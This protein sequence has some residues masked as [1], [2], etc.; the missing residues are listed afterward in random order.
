MSRSQRRNVPATTFTFF[1]TRRFLILT[2]VSVVALSGLAISQSAALREKLRLSAA[3]KPAPGPQLPLPAAARNR[4]DLLRVMGVKRAPGQPFSF[5]PPAAPTVSATKTD[6]LFNDVDNDLQADPGDT[7]KYT[8]NINASGSDATGV[9]FT[10]TVDPNT[11]FVPGSLRATPVAVDDTYAATG[12]I[13]ISVAAPGVLGNDFAGI[14]SASI[15]APP[16]TSANGGDVTLNADGSFTYNPPA[17]FEGTDTF[18]YTLTNSEGSNSATVTINVSG[19][20]WFI[21]N[22]ASCPCDGRLTTPFNTLASFAAVNNG[23]GNNPAANDN[24]FLYESASDYVG[25]VTLL[26]GQRFIGQDATASL[27][28]ITGLTPPAGSDPLPVTNS[29]NGTIVNITTGSAITVASGNTLTGFTGGDST[30]DIT[31]TGFGTL[32]ISD[33]TLNGT[34]QALNLTT[35]TLAATFGSISSTNSATTGI[36]LTGVAGTLT[37]PTTTITN[38]TGIGMSVGTSSATLGFGNTTSTGS[39]GT[40]V[41]LLT[42]SG[43][44]TFGALNISPD[45]NQR[46]LLA[47][48]N[49]N[50]ITSASGTISTSGATAIEVTRGVG[51]T[52]LAISQTSVSASGGTNGIVLSN[53]NG[54]FTVTGSGGACSTSVNCTGGAVLN[55]TNAVLLTNATNISID[56]MFIQNTTDSGVKGTRVTNFTF[57]NGWID[58]SGTGLA[59]QTSNIAF[60]TTAA[61][62]ENNLSGTV[63]ITGNTLLNAYFHGIDIF[64]FNGT[65][66][67][68]NISNN[69]ITSTTSTATSKGTGIRIVAFGSASTV[70]N[71]NDATISGNT[72]TNFPSGAGITV[73]GGNANNAAAPQGTLG[74]PNDASNLIDITGNFISGASSAIKMG[75]NAIQTSTNGVGRMNVNIANNGTAGSPITNIVGTVISL[76]VLG[77]STGTATI[78]NN[79]IVA[80]HTPNFGGPIGISAGTGR[81]F[82]VTDVPTL[83]L[84]I[85]GNNVSQTD[86]AGIQV[87]AVEAQGSINLSV[88]TNT[89]AA[90]IATAVRSGIR[91]DAGASAAGSDNDVC[92]DIQNNT[93]A[94]GTDGVDTAPGISLRKQGTS[95]TVNAFGIEGMGATA[96]PGVENYVNGLNPGSSSGTVGVGGTLLLS[97]TSGFSNCA[98]APAL[99]A[100]DGGGESSANGSFESA[101][102]ISSQDDQDI[103]YAAPGKG[104]GGNDIRKLSQADL[105]AMVQPAIE[106]W[107]QAGISAEDLVRLQAV[108]FEIADLPEDRMAT[109]TSTSVR[110]DET[111]AEYG[112]YF[113]LSPMEDSEFDVPVP[114]RELHTSENSLAFG[115]MDL[116]TVVMR[117]LGH[118]YKQ[119]KKDVPKQLRPLMEKTLSPA[120]R[121]VPDSRNIQLRRSPLGASNTNQPGKENSLA[122]RA[123]KRST[124]RP[125]TG[126][127]TAPVSLRTAGFKQT[128]SRQSSRLL[129]HASRNRMS[130]AGP[131]SMLAD[132]MLSI[133]TLPAGETVTITFNVTVDDPFTG[134]LPQVSNQG[135]V[136]GSNFADVLTDDPTVGGAADPTVTPID[137]PDV[138]V[139]VSPASVAEDGAANLVYTFTR[140]GSTANAMTVNFSIGG[141]ANF[142]ASPNDYT[143]TGAATFTPPTGTV[144]FGAGNSTATVTVN[145][146]SDT[147]VEPDET[148]VLT[149]TS[150]TGYNVGSPSSASGTIT[151][152]DT[153]VSVAVSP[154]SVTED[155]AG[156]LVYTFTRVGVTTNALTV[157]FSIDA[158]GNNAV[159]P[160]DYGQS[161]AATFVPP[162]GTVTFGAGSSTATVTVDPTPDLLV[163]PDETVIFTVTS[164]AGYNVGSPSAATG[165]ITNDDADVSVTVSPGS[166]SEDGATNL[167]YT[168]TRTGFTLLP[169]TVNFSVGGTAVFSQPDYTQTGAATYSDTSGTVVFGPGDATAT[170]TI[171]PSAD[172]TV[173]PDE[174]V[175]LTVTSGVGYNVGSPDSATGTITN[176][177][178]NVSVAVSP[179][180]VAEDGATNLV[181]TFTRTGVTSGALTVSFSVG[182]TATFGPSPDDYTQTG[183]TTFT[184]TS[185]S[186]TFATGNS[187]ATVTINPET[188]STV[189]PDE[190]VDLTLTP[191]AGYNVGSPSSASGTITNDDTDVSVAVSPASVAEDGATNLVYTFVRSGVTSG[192]LT[193]NFSVGGTATFGPS[194]DDYTQ[195]GATTFTTT[196]GSVTFAPGNSMAT[197]TVNPETDTTIEPDETVILSLTSGAGYNVSSP[198]SATGTI[199]NDDAD[200]SVAVSPAAVTEDGATNLVYTFT[201]TGFT[202]G[203]L[204]VNFAVGGSATFGPSPDDYTETGAS[205]FT[206][207]SGSVTFAPGNSTASVTVNPETDTTAESDETV[208]ITLTAGASYNVVTPN[209]ATGTILNDDT[210]VSVVVSPTS[211]AEG[212]ANL[213]YTFTRTGPTAS[214]VT[215]NFSVGGTASFP[216][217][218][219]QSGATT[220]TPPTATVTFGVGS[221]TATVTVTPL[222]DCTVEGDET[223]EFTV[224]P[225]SGYG[226]GSPNTATGTITNTPDSG[227]PTITLIPNVNMTLWPPN[228]DYT[229]VA[230]TD[231]VASASDDCDPTVDVNSVYI[232]KISS[233]EAEDGAADGNTLNDIVIGASCRTAQ[234]RA[235]RSASGNGRV[236]TITFKVKD[237]AG[238]STTATAQVTVRTSPNNP[239]VDSGA[240]YTVNS[241]CP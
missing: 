101:A 9:T 210:L 156:N 166:V 61:G 109:A 24:I 199:T 115:R 104:P 193:V 130:E 123:G 231:F 83:T 11:A 229:S 42:N 74:I 155:G 33:V 237:S 200:V 113:D 90:P 38:P 221:S 12:N 220:F 97:A 86:G 5:L 146:E 15:T 190:T 181:Y 145:P 64:N 191:G 128:A 16:V 14:P 204:T 82:A 120:V 63:T 53:T 94:G 39:G 176:D 34:G 233:D 119:G 22:T 161:G 17:G 227:A 19:M 241:S 201:R 118:V 21:N 114:N 65:I 110:I 43:A 143:Q 203:A 80:N 7:I 32:T 68:A 170:V 232:L 28:A 157:N 26:N 174:T 159:F 171:D 8:V 175:I 88:K 147:T 240:V 91:V 125:K 141:T 84:S 100:P 213:V 93:T 163:E 31:G 173:E 194:P 23:A 73:Q 208:V 126:V 219:S 218:Y 140:N 56:R 205:T 186:V 169:A 99:I 3:S 76:S 198:F 30:T 209:S 206:T 135:T 71:V 207:T 151:N 192:A 234:L 139:A 50:T 95:T 142:G 18:S 222:T 134:A 133:G 195:T 164:G 214:A 41:S 217:D 183:A 1:R 20:I 124:L 48:D 223:V 37:T 187:T 177:D 117:E 236:Y 182:G 197:V 27:S 136:S 153:N 77:K 98:T 10:D 106:R 35:G 144:T 196:S 226:V 89:V 29:A 72:I 108:T 149:L 127:A 121:R 132:V 40:G 103:L 102:I 230:V 116:L 179:G 122:S 235:E 160:A 168:F 58:N 81:T 215:A 165:T 13:R 96:T 46:G 129:N 154:A 202:A 60:N 92:L 51:T 54:S 211:T 44:I 66:A 87:R 185:G 111:A 189:E 79:R 25:P 162:V 107:R 188:D 70:A 224:Q 131:N 55:T 225:G 59:A 62:T 105:L 45:A 228:H 152:D 36:S 212:G 49:S 238:N 57:T 150:G 172:T 67:D 4:V 216:A 178:T 85:T 138:S 148:V 69:T 184:T 75:T 78:T 239:A 6:S 167:V 137:L 158:G 112:W 2:L 180:S 52:P 47:T